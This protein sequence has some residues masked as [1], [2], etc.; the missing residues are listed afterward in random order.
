ML[1]ALEWL[2]GRDGARKRRWSGLPALRAIGARRKV[3]TLG[4]TA[5]A[6]EMAATS[7][8]PVA[9]GRLMAPV[10]TAREAAIVGVPGIWCGATGLIVVGRRHGLGGCRWRQPQKVWELQVAFV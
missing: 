5:G 3:Q 6:E 1:G 7:S 9:A 8:R 2:D 10:T 4:L